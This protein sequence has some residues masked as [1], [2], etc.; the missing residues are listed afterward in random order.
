MASIRTKLCLSAPGA[1]SGTICYVVGYKH[2]ERKITT[3]YTLPVKMWCAE[4]S[5]FSMPHDAESR[6]LLTRIRGAVE[7]DMRRLRRIVACF[8]SSET[9][10]S[11]DDVVC[12][13]HRYMSRYSVFGYFGSVIKHI[14]GLGKERTAET[15]HAALNSFMR[16]RGGVDMMLDTFGSDDAEAYEAWLRG[17]RL[18][19]NTISFYTR[20]FRAVY[21]RAAE[22]G[23]FENRHPFRHVYTG[24]DKT[25]KRALPVAVVGRIKRLD[26]S[27]KPCL[28]FARDIFMLSFYL[29]GMSFIDMAY[30][31]KSDLSGGRITYRRRK[32][33]QQLTIAWTHEMQEILDKYPANDSNYL[34]PIIRRDDINPRYAYRNASYTINRNLKT[35]AR[36]LRLDI[37]LTLYVARHSWASAAKAKGIPVMVISEGMGHDSE[38]TT[39]IYLSQLDTSVVDRANATIINGL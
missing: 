24:I 13:Y 32:T 23:G 33:G 39:Q 5:T 8:E 35:V 4:K 2:K 27:R 18:V 19:P 16:F 15:Y 37:S 6:K 10:Y 11:A 31:R 28:D 21:N 34:M 30:L 3:A 14:G 25:V 17:R 26:L 29:R 12:E 7:A 1:S 36:L 9:D 22:E 38:T 20:I